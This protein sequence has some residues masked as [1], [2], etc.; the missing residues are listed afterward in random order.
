MQ[1]YIIHSL[2]RPLLVQLPRLARSE[3]TQWTECLGTICHANG[4]LMIYPK[5][6]DVTIHHNEDDVKVLSSRDG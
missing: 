5:T 6:T 1:L 4:Y 3:L 2:R